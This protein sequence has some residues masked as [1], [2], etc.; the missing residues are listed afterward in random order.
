[1]LYSAQENI[2]GAIKCFEYAIELS[3]NNNYIY[4]QAISNE[5]YAE[6]L[7]K[8]R[9]GK[10]FEVYMREAFYLYDKWGGSSKN[11]SDGK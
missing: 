3:R 6:F 4:I 5:A 10:A 9:M 1:M 8:F 7:F 2:D 11:Y